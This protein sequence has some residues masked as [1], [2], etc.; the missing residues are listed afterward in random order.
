MRIEYYFTNGYWRARNE[1]IYSKDSNGFFHKDPSQSARDKAIAVISH[2]FTS[3]ITS[4]S[5]IE[6]R[7]EAETIDKIRKLEVKMQERRELLAKLS[8]LDK[9]IDEMQRSEVTTD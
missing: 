8:Q 4:Q 7:K 3:F 6:A 1:E 9:E 5:G 2:A